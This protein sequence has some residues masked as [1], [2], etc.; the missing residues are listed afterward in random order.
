MKKTEKAFLLSILVFPGA[1]HILLKRYIS[2]FFLIIIASVASYFLIYGAI[3]QALEIADKI[4][5]GEIYPDLSVI[6]TLVSNQSASSEFQSLNTAMV[7]L[8]IVWLVGIVDTY[9]LGRQFG[10]NVTAKN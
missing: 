4:K 7:A 5:S 2:G 8:L 10:R 6:L 1:G 9:R 3:Y